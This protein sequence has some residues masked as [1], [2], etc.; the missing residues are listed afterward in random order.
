MVH[1]HG[2]AGLVNTPYNVVG[3]RL[4]NF[5]IC[6]ICL[7]YHTAKHIRDINVEGNPDFRIQIILGRPL[8]GKLLSP[9]FELR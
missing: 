7:A 5:D 3:I 1:L 9:G 8:N 6:N 4:D 2:R